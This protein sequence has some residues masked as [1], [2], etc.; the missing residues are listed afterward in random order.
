M[1]AWKSNPKINELQTVLIVSQDAEMVNVWQALFE[2]KNCRV[3]CETG[4]G[5]ALQTSRLL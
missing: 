3:V 5:E 1:V 2:Q 4:A